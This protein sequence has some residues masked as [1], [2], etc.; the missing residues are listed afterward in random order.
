VTPDGKC[1]CEPGRRERSESAEPETRASQEKAAKLN[2]FWFPRS[3]AANATQDAAAFNTERATFP[4]EFLAVNEHT[5]NA[6]GVS[7]TDRQAVNRR[8]RGVHLLIHEV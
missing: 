2:G 1:C 3:F 4:E 8:R 5:E 7:R 6:A